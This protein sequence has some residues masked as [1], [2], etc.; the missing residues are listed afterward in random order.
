MGFEMTG[1][2]ALLDKVLLPREEAGLKVALSGFAVAAVGYCLTYSPLP[3]DVGAWVGFIGA[4]TGVVGVVWQSI[5][6]V[7][8]R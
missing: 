1:A 6:N 7:Q 5:V 4:A 8:G 3:F 2:R